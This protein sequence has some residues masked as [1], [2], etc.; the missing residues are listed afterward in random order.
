M[1]ST[2]NFKIIINAK[3][4]EMAASDELFAKNLQKENKNIDD[5]INY[6]LNTVYKSGCNGFIDDE[7]FAMAAHYYDED[8]VEAGKPIS[9]NVVVNHHPELSQE[10]KQQAKKEAMEQLIAEEREKLHKKV[11]VKK[12]TAENTYQPSLF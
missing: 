3:L 1:K 11:P 10:E 12:V 5:C 2:E 4:Q 9:C 7:I 6:I 8:G